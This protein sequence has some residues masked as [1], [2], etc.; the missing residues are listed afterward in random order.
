MDQPSSKDQFIK[1]YSFII[2]EDLFARFNGTGH[3]AETRKR[4]LLTVFGSIVSTE[5]NHVL[6]LSNNEDE[7]VSNYMTLKR[8]IETCIERAFAKVFELMNP[9]THPD[10][11]CNIEM[12][13][14]GFQDSK[15]T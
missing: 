13:D 5:F 6:K 4:I 12:L 7:A 2:I 3:D 8:D 9:G 11:T 14:A 1:D 15:D 10:F